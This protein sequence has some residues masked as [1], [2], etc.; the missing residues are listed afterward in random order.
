MEENKKVL[1]YYDYTVILTYIGMLV[2]FTGI[3]CVMEGR[4]R[5]AMLCLMAAGICDMLDGTVAATKERTKREKRF[6]VQ[7]DSLS[8]LICF[9]ALPALFV[10]EINGKSYPAFLAAGFYILCALVRLA[11]FNVMEEERQNREDGCRKLYLGL[12]VTTIALI[13]PTCYVI[14]RRGTAG[15]AGSYIAVLF[16]TAAAFLLPFRIKKP[17]LAGKVGITIA[18]AVEF[19]II[20]TGTVLDV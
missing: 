11:Y 3:T 2:G 13:L 5:Q 9:G 19:I 16:V 17:Y 1:G 8:D 18:G 14:Q 6:G 15:S 4:F 10:Y 12:P 7:I 20:L